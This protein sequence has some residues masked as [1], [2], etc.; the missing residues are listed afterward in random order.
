MDYGLDDQGSM[1]GRRKIFLLPIVFKPDL[2]FTQPPV[3]WIIG[4]MSPRMKW[5]WPETDYS[6]PVCAEVKKGGAISPRPY[7]SSWHSA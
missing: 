2:G 7:K 4:A 3:Q 1:P 6:S 5:S